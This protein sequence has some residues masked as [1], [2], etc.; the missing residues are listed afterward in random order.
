MN[1]ECHLVS[2]ELSW[3]GKEEEEEEK[4]CLVLIVYFRQVLSTSQ[5]KN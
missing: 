4:A 3:I 2:D 1:G 5:E